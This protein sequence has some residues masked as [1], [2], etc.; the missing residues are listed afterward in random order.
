MKYVKHDYDVAETY[1]PLIFP[2]PLLCNASESAFH[3]ILE[4]ST[5]DCD[6]WCV[7]C[8]I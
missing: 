5:N 1:D 8:D 2:I 6:M 7:K 4:H 3:L